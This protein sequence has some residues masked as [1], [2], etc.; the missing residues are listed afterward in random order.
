MPLER[1]I[2]PFFGAALAASSLPA[3]AETRSYTADYT[4]TFLGIPVARATFTSTIANDGG[5]EM[6]GSWQSAGLAR[7]FS[8]TSG[9]ANLSARVNGRRVEPQNFQV[10][11]NSGG[12][13]DG[14]AIRFQEGSAVAVNHRRPE[15]DRRSTYIPITP[16]HLRSVVDPLSA[17]LVRA[18]SPGEV[19]NRRLSVF[20]GWLRADIQLRPVSTGP[21][22]R[23]EGEGAVCAGSFAPVAG[24]NADSRD[25]RHMRDSGD[26]SITYAPLGDTELYAPVDASIGTRV[27]V[28]RISAGPLRIN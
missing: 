1:L 2:V 11:F 19:C 14:V 9:N 12:R 21:L 17:T 5:L 25:M 15:P 8:R 22:P 27:G 10:A 18:S 6:R 23:H 20:D 7:V 4:A 13:P 24:F 16:E 3:A 26:I 28:V